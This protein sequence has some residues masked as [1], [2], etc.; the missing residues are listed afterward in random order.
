MST[1]T[2]S[3]KSAD[4]VSN[5]V[6][7]ITGP[8]WV[9]RGYFERFYEPDIRKEVDAGSSFILGAADGIDAFA[10]ELLAELCPERV[11]VCNKGAK[12]GR[13]SPRMALHNG[14]ASYPDR[15]M[16]MAK[17]C[18]N[19]ICVLPQFGCG[20]TG[21]LLPLLL[22]RFGASGSVNAITDFIRKSCEEW[23]E[24]VL[25]DEIVPLYERLYP[26]KSRIP[27]TTT[28]RS[29]AIK[30]SKTSAQERLKHWLTLTNVGVEASAVTDAAWG[31]IECLVEEN[32]QAEAVPE[33][34][35]NN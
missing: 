21:A 22:S 20:T 30:E 18:T 6:I 4:L 23:N 34:E 28:G 7:L 17:E 5:R 9:N 27:T 10:Q 1:A 13:K 19:V 14:F 16:H 12:D 25:R 35:S 8:Q 26:S 31:G 29:F 33:A 24:T 15:D 32:N 2:N 3:E 11:T